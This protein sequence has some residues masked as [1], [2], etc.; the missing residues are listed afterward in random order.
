VLAVR[1]LAGELPSVP[2]QTSAEI[3]LLLLE[4]EPESYIPAARRLLARLADERSMPL[5]QLADV[6]AILAELEADPAPMAGGKK[7]AQSFNARRARDRTGL[8]VGAAR[9]PRWTPGGME[10][11][12]GGGLLQAGIR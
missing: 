12:F 3:T 5:R 1:S 8:A 2:L 6:A 4:R 9:G 7:L 10:R 11:V